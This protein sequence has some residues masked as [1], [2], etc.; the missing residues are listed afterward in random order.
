MRLYVDV[1]SGRSGELLFRTRGHTA[2]MQCGR[3]SAG[4]GDI[5]VDVDGR[6][7]VAIGKRYDTHGGTSSGSA[8]VVRGLPNV[9]TPVCAASA[10]PNSSGS[11]ARLVARGSASKAADAIFLE[12]TG[13]PLTRPVRF[14]RGTTTT[15]VPFGNGVWCAGG[16]VVRIG[17]KTTD[18]SGA[19]N[20]LFRPTS[21]Q[22]GSTLVFQAWLDDPLAGGAG[23]NASDAASLVLVP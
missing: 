7:D 5:D 20:K 10:T 9:G 21:I 11:V 13:A 23:F 3:G 2:D 12:L 22:V 17:R 16:Q 18:A 14:L 15:L 8:I 4:P 19:A 1:V 6:P